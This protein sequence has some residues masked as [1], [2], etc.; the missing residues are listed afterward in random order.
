M[1]LARQLID[2][3][4]KSVVVAFRYVFLKQKTLLTS[5]KQG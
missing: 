5:G 1:S 2:P 3:D 4:L